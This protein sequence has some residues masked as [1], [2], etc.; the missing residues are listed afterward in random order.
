MLREQNRRG[1]AVAAGTAPRWLRI[2]GVW[3]FFS[4]ISIWNTDGGAPF[5]RRVDFFLGL[6][7]LA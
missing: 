4:L 1:Q 6:F 3:T 7:C 2:F 5:L